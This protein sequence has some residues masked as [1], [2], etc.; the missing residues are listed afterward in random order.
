VRG[1]LLS[2]FQVEREHTPVA[3]AARGVQQIS[4]SLVCERI[5]DGATVRSVLHN[6]LARRPRPHCIGLTRSKNVS[7]KKLKQTQNTL[8]STT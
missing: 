3:A 5:N 7:N 6:Q 4:D 1:V 8:A 2:S